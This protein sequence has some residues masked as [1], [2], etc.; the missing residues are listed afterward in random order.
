MIL[1]SEVALNGNKFK[2]APTQDGIG[3]C[4]IIASL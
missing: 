1:G 2:R 4:V 3:A